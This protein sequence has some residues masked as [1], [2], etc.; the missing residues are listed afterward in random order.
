MKSK[1]NISVVSFC[2]EGTDGLQVDG[3]SQAF[4][5]GWVFMTSHHDCMLVQV[6]VAP[7]YRDRVC[8]KRNGDLIRR[9]LNRNTSFLLGV[10]DWGNGVH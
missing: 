5:K 2:L 10:R 3:M 8:G 1:F 4:P 7:G 6:R 9:G